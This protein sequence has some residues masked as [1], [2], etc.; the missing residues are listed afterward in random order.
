MV[1]IRM[2]RMSSIT[3]RDVTTVF[4]Y[5]TKVCKLSAHVLNFTSIITQIETDVGT[6]LLENKNNE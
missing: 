5:M 4:R 3:V 1:V 6:L 2:F